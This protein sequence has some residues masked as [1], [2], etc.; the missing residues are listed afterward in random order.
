MATLE[1]NLTGVGDRPALLIIDASNG[2]TDP[3]YPTGS[4]YDSE[5][6]NIGRLLERFRAL[7]LPVYFTTVAYTN[8]EQGKI[9]RLKLPSTNILQQGAHCVEIDSRLAPRPDE[10]L[11]V[12]YLP[13]GFFETD[14]K[15]RLLADGVDTTFVVGFTTSGCVRA[16]AVDAM[17]SGFR[18][19]VVKDACGDRDPPAHEANLHDLGAKYADIVTL[20]EAFKLLESIAVAA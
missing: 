16:S 19:V 7:G 15:E 6:A 2:F 11:I 1:K 18:T 3:S 4:S 20:D 14:L 9:F 10:T 12:K 8:E 17:S 13:S 5:V